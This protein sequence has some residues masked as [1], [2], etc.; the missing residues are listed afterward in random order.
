MAEEVEEQ[1]E[2]DQKY[3]TTTLSKTNDAELISSLNRLVRI[4][5]FV[6]KEILELGVASAKQSDKYK[7]A[8]QD[9]KA[10]LEM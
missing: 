5:G 8:L 10:E 7:K 1:T 6:T 4:G 2:K 9:V 3:V